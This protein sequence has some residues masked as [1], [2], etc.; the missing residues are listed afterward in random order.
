MA[1]LSAVTGDSAIQAVI[2]VIRLQMPVRQILVPSDITPVAGLL[3]KPM[4]VP[5][6]QVGAENVLDGVKHFRVA[7]QFIHPSEHEMRLEHQASAQRAALAALECLQAG[8]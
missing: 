2:C 4:R 1:P 6:E 5:G 3:D 8:G 7:D